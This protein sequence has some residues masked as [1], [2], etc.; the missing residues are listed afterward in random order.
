M[1]EVGDVKVGVPVSEST[2]TVPPALVRQIA[3]RLVEYTAP[4]YR[5]RK[6]LLARMMEV[7]HLNAKWVEQSPPIEFELPEFELPGHQLFSD[8]TELSHWPRAIWWWLVAVSEE[9]YLIGREERFESLAL[10]CLSLVR[11]YVFSGHRSPTDPPEV[12]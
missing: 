11:P 12:A 8:L 1:A 2:G 4:L 10:E 9:G 7:A 6:R 5:H 3:W